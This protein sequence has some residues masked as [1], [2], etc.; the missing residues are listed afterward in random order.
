MIF[1]F[2]IPMLSST[3][4]KNVR[5]EYHHVLTDFTDYKYVKM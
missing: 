4:N 3:L 5:F 1:M 2:E